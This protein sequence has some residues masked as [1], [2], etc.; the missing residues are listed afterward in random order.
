MDE[1]DWSCVMTG[2]RTVTPAEDPVEIDCHGGVLTMTRGFWKRV[3]RTGVRHGR[4]RESLRSGLSLNGRMDLS[5]AEAV[6]DVIH[7]QNELCVKSL[8]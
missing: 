2:P 3:L 7:A 8:L 5:E 1:V 4:A 6:M